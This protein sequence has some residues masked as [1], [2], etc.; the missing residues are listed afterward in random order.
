MEVGINPG[1]LEFNQKMTGR[2]HGPGGTGEYHRAE[3]TEGLRPE[4]RWYKTEAI[5]LSAM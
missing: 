5:N 2:S 1:F 4:E 3:R